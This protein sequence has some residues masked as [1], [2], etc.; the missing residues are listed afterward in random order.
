MLCTRQL[1]YECLRSRAI[2]VPGMVGA[3]AIGA[4]CLNQLSCLQEVQTL[5]CPVPPAADSAGCVVAALFV[6]VAKP[7]AVAASQR[8]W[9]EGLCVKFAPGAQ[10]HVFSNSACEGH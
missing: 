10:V 4:P 2:P 9:I 5:L 7:L 6:V 1:V 8:L 3:L